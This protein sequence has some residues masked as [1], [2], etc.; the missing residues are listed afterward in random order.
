MPYDWQTAGWTWWKFV[1]TT[2]S[3][4][5]DVNDAYGDENEDKQQCEPTMIC[6][7][8]DVL[9][10]LTF[11][12]F[13]RSVGNIGRHPRDRQGFAADLTRR[14]AI[15]PGGGY[16]TDYARSELGVG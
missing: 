13:N 4:Q 9:S 6:H 1:F 12:Y 11:Y 14:R 10:P 2:L 8:L 3:P 7:N 5:Q 16:A 15:P